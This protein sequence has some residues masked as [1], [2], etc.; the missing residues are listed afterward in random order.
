MV[1]NNQDQNHTHLPMM[2]YFWLEK[3]PDYFQGL[4]AQLV[5]KIHELSQCR[6]RTLQHIMTAMST[7]KILNSNKTIIDTRAE[8]SIQK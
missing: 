5:L 4:M 2:Q 8:R 3:F 6:K 7:P 1:Q